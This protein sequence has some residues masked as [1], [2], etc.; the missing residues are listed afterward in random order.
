MIDPK[1]VSTEDTLIMLE[2]IESAIERY[3]NGDD[4]AWIIAD[5]ISEIKTICEVVRE[6]NNIITEAEIS[7]GQTI[8]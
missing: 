6:L 1:K 2:R 3:E 8:R 7:L 5:C 4:G